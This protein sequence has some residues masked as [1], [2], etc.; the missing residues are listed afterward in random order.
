M[1]ARPANEV[2]ITHD[3]NDLVNAEI[4]KLPKVLAPPAAGRRVG[5][6]GRVTDL[7]EI[8]EAVVELYGG[9]V[10]RPTRRAGPHT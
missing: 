7:D 6:P 8:Q 5:E 2:V 3:E 1:I 10:V 4:I 9:E